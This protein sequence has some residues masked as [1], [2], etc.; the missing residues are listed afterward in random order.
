M[1]FITGILI[2]F[3]DLKNSY[4]KSD[5]IF[6]IIAMLVVVALGILY[7]SNTNRMGIAEYI[8]KTFDL[9]GM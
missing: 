8:L 1:F 5:I 2:D 3:K 4:K 9:G 6:Y 7:Y